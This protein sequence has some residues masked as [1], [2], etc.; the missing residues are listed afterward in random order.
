MT[1]RTAWL[2]LALALAG[3][4]AGAPARDGAEATLGGGPVVDR[5]VLAGGGGS[6]TGGA[7]RIDGTIGQV[8]ADPLHPASGGA[9]AISGGFWAGLAPTPPSGEAVFANGFEPAS[10]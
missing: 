8:D 1:A 3:T 4:A 9:F 6:S 5:H 2:A 7:F 10:P